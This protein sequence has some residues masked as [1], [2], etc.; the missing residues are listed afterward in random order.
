MKN[1]ASTETLLTEIYKPKFK[2][3]GNIAKAGKWDRDLWHPS[4]EGQI[5]P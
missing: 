5:I 4:E 3:I 2:K 1:Y